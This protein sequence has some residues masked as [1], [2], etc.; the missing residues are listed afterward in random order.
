MKSQN[1]M[2]CEYIAKHP[3]CTTKDVAHHI[4][5]SVE[6][7]SKRL[8]GLEITDHVRVPT[9]TGRYNRWIVGTNQR[10]KAS[11]NYYKAK[12]NG[13]GTHYPQNGSIDRKRVV[14]MA[15]TAQDA[16][17]LLSAGYSKVKV[18]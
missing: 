12:G 13:G 17:A 1:Q 4:G 7:T 15:A 14:T 10:F 16:L 6:N 11:T 2:I 8:N 3:L 9:K 18:V 5:N